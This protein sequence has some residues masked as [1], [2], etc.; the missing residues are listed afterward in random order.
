MF[1]S[2]LKEGY[3]GR[4]T[5]ANLKPKCHLFHNIT[6]RTIITRAGS[7]DKVNNSDLNVVYHLVHKKPL[8]IGYLILAH[9]KRSAS[10]HCSEPY[11]MLLTKI[12]KEFNVPLDDEV[13]LD[14]CDVIDG[15]I[16]GRLRIATVPNPKR[17]KTATHKISKSVKKKGKVGEA[18]AEEELPEHEAELS[19]SGSETLEPSVEI[20]YSTP[21]PEPKSPKEGSGTSKAKTRESEDSSESEGEPENENKDEAEKENVQQDHAL[22]EDNFTPDHSTP[23]IPSPRKTPSPIPSPLRNLNEDVQEGFNYVL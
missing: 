22:A 9:M 14:E 7:W 15:S 17:K 1:E 13:G 12:L 20:E 4:P 19:E 11:A 21:E 6:V 23:H 2:F 3:D 5:A 10:S 8:N 16:L 18:E